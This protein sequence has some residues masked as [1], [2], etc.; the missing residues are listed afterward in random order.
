MYLDIFKIYSL[1]YD[2]IIQKMLAY[3]E[4]E[5]LWNDKFKC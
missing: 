4:F 5:I 1:R 3:F 2:M